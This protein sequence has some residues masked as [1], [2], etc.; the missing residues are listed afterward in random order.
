MLNL[1]FVG[2]HRLA[3]LV[4]AKAFLLTLNIRC[5]FRFCFR[6]KDVGPCLGPCDSLQLKLAAATYT[7]AVLP[8]LLQASVHA[9]HARPHVDEL[10]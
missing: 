6:F 7:A 8:L 3:H 1:L 9:D 5:R 2:Y 10:A 4:T